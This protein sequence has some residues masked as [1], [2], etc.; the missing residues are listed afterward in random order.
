M[1]ADRIVLGI[2]GG[3]DS[4]V[5]AALL[6]R[7]GRDVHALFMRNWDDDDG[8]CTAAADLQDARRVCE[9]L[10]VPLHV[11]NFAAEYRERVFRHFLDELAAGRTPNPDVACNRE[12][13]FGVCLEHAQRLGA[14]RFATGHYA[15]VEHGPDGPRLRRAA[16]RAKDQS[17]FLHTVPGHLTPALFSIDKNPKLWDHEIMRSHKDSVDLVFRPGGV[18]FLNEAGAK[19]NAEKVLETVGVFNLY[20][21]PPT[22]RWTH[23]EMAQRAVLQNQPVDQAIEWGAS[24]FKRMSDDMKNSIIGAVSA[25]SSTNTLLRARQALYLVATSSQYQVQR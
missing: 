5:A 22:A 18:Y 15:R 4:A 10:A 23:A 24:E 12:I 11:V 20:A 14:S 2:S 13:K 21:G 6:V 19:P 1:N 3:V 17:Y 9:D 16:D 25:V 7:E 8:Y